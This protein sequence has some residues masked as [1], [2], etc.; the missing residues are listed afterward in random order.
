MPCTRS[1]QSLLWMGMSLLMI[2][3]L[4]VQ[5]D[6]AQDCT[7]IAYG[8]VSGISR[9]HAIAVTDCRYNYSHATNHVDCVPLSKCSRG[10]ISFMFDNYVHDRSM[11]S[12]LVVRMLN[13]LPH[14]RK[15]GADN[16]IIAALLRLLGNVSPSV[17]STAMLTAISHSHS[18]CYL[19]VRFLLRL[20]HRIIARR[21]SPY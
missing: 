4:Y 11:S 2:A 5:T 6:V 7:F 1:Q 3:S 18:L 19:A 15:L 9:M 12:L 21:C 13:P 17:S 10:V 8:H 16:N 14:L 20:Q